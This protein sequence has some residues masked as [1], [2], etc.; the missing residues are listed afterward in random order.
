MSSR[1]HSLTCWNSW[2]RVSAMVT[3]SGGQDVAIAPKAAGVVALTRSVSDRGVSGTMTEIPSAIGS[4]AQR[5]RA[6]QY[7]P[8]GPDPLPPV[9]Q[10]ARRQRRRASAA[11]SGPGTGRR[12][13]AARSRPARRPTARMAGVPDQRA[14]A[15]AGAVVRHETPPVGGE[16][17][18]GGHPFAVAAQPDPGPLAPR[19][20][21][22]RGREAGPGHPGPGRRARTGKAGPD[23]RRGDQAREVTEVGGRPLLEVDQGVVHPPAQVGQAEEPARRLRAP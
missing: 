17:F 4:A 10:F 5:C 7:L 3:G 22:N 19:P 8:R 6:D 11:C 9:R 13:P 20:A 12:S 16:A 23:G 21:A 15:G 1:P 14:T 18:T 2:T